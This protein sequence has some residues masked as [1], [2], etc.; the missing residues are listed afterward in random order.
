MEKIVA[1]P[2]SINPNINFTFTRKSTNANEY[3]SRQSLKISNKASKESIER[4]NICKNFLNDYY[5]DKSEELTADFNETYKKLSNNDHKEIKKQNIISPFADCEFLKKEEVDKKVKDFLSSDVLSSKEIE[6]NSLTKLKKDSN[7]EF[8]NKLS[9]EESRT[10]KRK[11]I[12]KREEIL[13]NKEFNSISN[14]LD[15]IET[16]DIKDMHVKYNNFYDKFMLEQD[17]LEYMILFS[18]ILVVF[19]TFARKYL[20]MINIDGIF[21]FFNEYK[22]DTQGYISKYCTEKYYYNK[23][24]NNFNIPQVLN[25]YHED[26]LISITTNDDPK[27][28]IEM[29]NKPSISTFVFNMIINFTS[30]ILIF[31]TKRLLKDYINNDIMES[32]VTWIDEFSKRFIQDSDS[33]KINVDQVENIQELIPNPQKRLTTNIIGIDVLTLIE[34]Y[35]S[36]A[37]NFIAV[38][39]AKPQEIVQSRNRKTPR[40]VVH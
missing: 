8:Y 7:F 1:R 19:E 26:T 16:D 37:I 4:V 30:K 10:L 17:I 40:V 27:I 36:S 9:S 5:P 28:I 20:T 15:Y 13:K 23:K 39:N 22:T 18:I 24:S 14:E 11:F 6:L 34:K 12:D 25:F 33:S 38:P 32:I 3:P 29:D 21:E 35:S 2:A 31:L